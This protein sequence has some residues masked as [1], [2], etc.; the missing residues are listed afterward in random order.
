MHRGFVVRAS[1]IA[2]SVGLSIASSSAPAMAEEIADFSG[3]NVVAERALYVLT[4]G[5]IRILRQLRPLPR[6]SPT[7]AERMR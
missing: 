1:I 3:S 7:L 5:R 6:S 4:G 2:A